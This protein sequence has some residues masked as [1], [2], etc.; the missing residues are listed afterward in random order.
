M[1]TVVLAALFF[2]GIHPLISGSIIPDHSPGRL[3]GA[4]RIEMGRRGC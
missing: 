4:Q 3:E 1:T 2:A